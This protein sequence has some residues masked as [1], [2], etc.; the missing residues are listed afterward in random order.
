MEGSLLDDILDHL[1]VAGGLVPLD[2]RASDQISGMNNLPLF[3]RNK[4]NIQLFD[5]FR[6]LNEV[7]EPLNRLPLLF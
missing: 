2:S 4:L 3:R 6:G 7:R 1:A 5:Q